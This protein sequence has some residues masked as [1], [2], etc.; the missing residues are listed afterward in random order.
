MAKLNC[1]RCNAEFEPKNIRAEFCSDKCRIYFYRKQKRDE[2]LGVPA[3]MDYKVGKKHLAAGNVL[4]PK[5][6]LKDKSNIPKIEY[7]FPVKKIGE[8]QLDFNIRL[9]EWKNK[10]K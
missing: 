4:K 2:K 9:E 1:K 5:G 10:N 3:L 7:D 8:Q 6:T